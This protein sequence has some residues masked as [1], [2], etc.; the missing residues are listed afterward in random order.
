M[1]VRTA[2]SLGSL[3]V[4]AVPLGLACYLAD[5]SEV[6]KTPAPAA[7]A[8]ATPA[9]SCQSPEAAPV[10]RDR[11]EASRCPKPAR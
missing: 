8:K 9:P 3:A 5:F 7:A 1:A 10:P 6:W 11:S 2:I 4:I